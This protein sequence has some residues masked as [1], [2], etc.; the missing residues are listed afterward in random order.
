MGKQLYDDFDSEFDGLQKLAFIDEAVGAYEVDQ[1]GIYFDRTTGKF[2]LLTASGCSCWNGEWN[3]EWYDSLDE[4]EEA[5][6]GKERTYNPSL[7]GAKEL[8]SDAR[9]AWRSR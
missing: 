6:M 5:L 2:G 7:S 9:E 8:I 1:A 4:L 3:A